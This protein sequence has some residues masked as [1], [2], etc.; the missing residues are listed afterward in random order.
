MLIQFQI[1]ATVG[2]EEKVQYLMD[3]FGIPQ[4]RIFNSRSADF[5]HDVKRETNGRGVDVVLNSLTGPLLHAS[6]DCLASFGRMIELG[7]RDFLSNGQLSMGPFIKNRSYIGFD[8]TQVG[9][10]AYHTYET[11]VPL[12]FSHSC[13]C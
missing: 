7:K 1:Y 13:G 9:K 6:W 4:H 2:S 5:L 11:Y 3:R 10:E 8:L 12:H